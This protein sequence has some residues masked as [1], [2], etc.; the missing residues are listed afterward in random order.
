MF[1]KAIDSKYSKATNGLKM[2]IQKRDEKNRKTQDSKAKKDITNT[3][4]SK[5]KTHAV[6]AQNHNVKKD[7]PNLQHVTAKEA[8]DSNIY[9]YHLDELESLITPKFRAKQIYNWLYKHYVS[10]IE[11][12]KNI[13]KNLQ[14]ILKQTFNFPNL[15]PIR[16]EESGDGTKKYLFQTS[17]GATFESVFIKMREK[18][19][20]E[21]NRVK[22]SEKYTFCVS[23]QVGCRV[24]CAFCSTAKGGFVRNLSAG[25]IVEQVVA[26]KRDNNLSAHKS[27]NIVF[28]GMGEPLDN[29]NNVAKAI[30]ILSHEEGLCIATRR[31]TISTSGIAPQIEK[32]GAMNLGVQIA[33]SLHAV[34]DSLRSRLIP[35]NKVYN[36]ERVLQALKN[37][38]LDTRKRILFEYLVIKDINDDLASAKKLVKLLHGFRAKVNLIPFNPHAESEFQRP[39]IEKMQSFADYLYKRGIVATIRE[40][41]GIDISAACGQLRA[42]QMKA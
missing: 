7:M 5:L 8:Q 23:S 4:D 40:S 28:M 39:C 20:D 16:I 6:K 41:K 2:T 11:S 10:N 21:N 25:E 22:K 14:E 19:Y 1:A 37:F 33:L 12:M 42:K 18:E 35:M 24:G 15:K 17:D 31:Q 36:I 29:L 38:P 13:P 9:S 34:D 27:I 32:L 30:K 26:L 3:Q